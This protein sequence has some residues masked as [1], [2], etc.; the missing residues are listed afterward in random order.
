MMILNFN[1][2]H[3]CLVF[4]KTF[5][6]ILKIALFIT[7]IPLISVKNHLT[8]YPQI[9]SNLIC[10]VS[11]VKVI[12]EGETRLEVIRRTRMSFLK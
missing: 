6:K 7:K 4:G 5:G 1:S 9:Q 8:L 11:T 2:F 12:S 3:F 10:D